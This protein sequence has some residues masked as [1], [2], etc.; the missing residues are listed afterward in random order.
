[1]HTASSGA[2]SADAANADSASGSESRV[3]R[4]ARVPGR[5]RR[6]QLSCCG[7]PEAG[8]G[9][10][11]AVSRPASCQFHGGIWLARLQETA[12]S[13]HQNR[14]PGEPFPSRETVPSRLAPDSSRRGV[15]D[16]LRDYSS[17]SSS[18]GTL[19]RRA[20]RMRAH[21]RP[22]D[23]RQGGRQAEARTLCARRTVCIGWH[24]YAGWC[25]RRLRCGLYD[26][27]PR[28]PAQSPA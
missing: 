2:V 3:H 8:A 11:P 18:G 24:V 5:R 13:L 7:R 26:R 15:G 6:V 21:E 19:V 25:L 20:S 4:G 16:A 17:G 10:W 12:G 23:A 22:R 14:A 28:S 27:S 1:M 9:A